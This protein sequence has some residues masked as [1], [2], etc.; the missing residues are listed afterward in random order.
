MA[1]QWLFF[2]WDV[3]VFGARQRCWAGARSAGA[4]GNGRWLGRPRLGIAKRAGMGY[5]DRLYTIGAEGHPAGVACRFGIIF[6]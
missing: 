2:C 1:M 6:T 5:G 3:L 4:S